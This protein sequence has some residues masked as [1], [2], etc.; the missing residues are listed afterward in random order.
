MPNLMQQLVL[1]E[2]YSELDF[3]EILLEDYYR[4]VAKSADNISKGFDLK[5]DPLLEHFNIS[6]DKPELIKYFESKPTE[7]VAL[8]FIDIVSF[9][10]LTETKGNE[11][12]TR[13]LDDYYKKAIPIV[14]ENGGQ[15]E[16]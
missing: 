11:F 12:I 6:N 1:K 16:N 13:Y 9:S 10:K 3:S 14:Y 15:V 4:R 7:D 2:K 5:G 8:L